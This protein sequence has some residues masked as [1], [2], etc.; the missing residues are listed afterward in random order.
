MTTFKISQVGRTA[1]FLPL[2]MLVLLAI[3]YEGRAHKLEQ[4]LPLWQWVMLLGTGIILEQIYKRT[5][6][7]SQRSLLFRDVLSSVINL[8]ITGAIAAALLYPIVV[9]FPE[10]FL[11]RKMILASSDQLGPLWVQVITVLLVTSFVR[12]WIH[13]FQHSV[14][15]LWRF[16]SYHHRTT[17][18]QIS[19]KYVSHPIDFALRNVVIFSVLY[20]VGFD[21]MAFFI[22]IPILQVAGAFD[23]CGADVRSGLLS[24]LLVTPEVHRWHHSASIPQGY[25]CSCNYGVEFSFWDIVFRTYYLPKNN[26]VAEHPDTIGFPGLP[27]ESSYLKSLFSPL[28]LYRAI[29]WIRDAVKTTLTVVSAGGRRR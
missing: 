9:Y 26:G 12:Y 15:F 22:A 6:R 16:H 23:H 27:D 10:R 3:F 24:Y 18:L 8:Y 13:R 29:A 25:G 2:L 28:G 4:W 20:I 19:N 1:I 5:W 21:S 7:V 17:D 11:G 14:P